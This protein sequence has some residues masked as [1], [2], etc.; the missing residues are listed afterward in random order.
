MVHL[1]HVLRELNT[2]RVVKCQMPEV[3]LGQIER[4]GTGTRRLISRIKKIK[5]AKEAGKPTSKVWNQ[6][7]LVKILLQKCKLLAGG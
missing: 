4:R 1:L 5:V 2:H 3:Y 7:V 6:A